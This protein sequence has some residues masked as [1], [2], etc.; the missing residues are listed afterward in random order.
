M[1]E[2]VVGT[3]EQGKGGHHQTGTSRTEEGQEVFGP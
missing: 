3:Y 2:T 1:E